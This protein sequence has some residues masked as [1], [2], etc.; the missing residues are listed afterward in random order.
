M[1][2]TF[3][4]SLHPSL[5]QFLQQCHAQSSSAL[6][7]QLPWRP[8]CDPSH[9]TCYQTRGKGNRRQHESIPQ[10]GST[11]GNVL[12]WRN[13]HSCHYLKN[14]FQIWKWY[15]SLV[16]NLWTSLGLQITSDRPKEQFKSK[17]AFCSC[18]CNTNEEW[19]FTG[20]WGAG[21]HWQKWKGQFCLLSWQRGFFPSRNEWHLEHPQSYKTPDISAH[22]W[23]QNWKFR[24]AS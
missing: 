20:N 24:S 19:C 5:C 3:S 22:L 21:N 2:E 16:F 10:F 6:Q 1:Q 4:D 8:C 14:H 12:H 15:N 7:N 11:Q 18:A 13:E 17:T 9:N 23:I